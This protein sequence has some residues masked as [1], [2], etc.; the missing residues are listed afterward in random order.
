MKI[1]ITKAL[2]AFGQ[3]MLVGEILDVPDNDAKV[4]IAAHHAKEAPADATAKP[5]KAL[6]RRSVLKRH[7]LVKK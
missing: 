6:D 3:R 4:W 5:W 7:G 2:A 1:I